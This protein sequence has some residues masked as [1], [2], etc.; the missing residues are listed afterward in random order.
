MEKTGYKRDV[1]NPKIGQDAATFHQMDKN[2][3]FGGEQEVEWAFFSR[4]VLPLD[5][6][7]LWMVP[8]SLHMD[9]NMDLD[10]SY[11][12]LRLSID[13]IYGGLHAL[14]GGTGAITKE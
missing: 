5:W 11:I 10:A 4:F 6:D 8:L 1:V 3:Q 9:W 14:E 12:A 13:R 2:N 7:T